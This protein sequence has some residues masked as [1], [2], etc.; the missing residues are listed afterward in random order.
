MMKKHK[1]KPKESII[2]YTF[3]VVWFLWNRLD[4]LKVK[5]ILNRLSIDVKNEEIG[6]T[7]GECIA[8][9]RFISDFGILKF[10]RNFL[11]DFIK[12]PVAI[13]LKIQQLAEEVYMKEG[14][15]QCQFININ[16]PIAVQ[17]SKNL[18]QSPIEI[19]RYFVLSAQLT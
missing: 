17:R 13:K 15:V 6:Q 5:Y 1:L 14:D 7:I 18:G 2:L 4:S 12:I 8:T 3:S 19:R 11:Y 9:Q 16:A 10:N